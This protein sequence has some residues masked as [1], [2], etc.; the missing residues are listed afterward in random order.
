MA[1]FI[2]L[3][4]D[5]FVQAFD[6]ELADTKGQE[7]RVRRPMRG[8]Q[9]RRDQP[10][11]ITIIDK[12]GKSIPIIDAGGDQE[13]K[14]KGYSARFTNFLVT[15]YSAT[16]QERSQIVQTFGEDF[17]FFYGDQPRVYQ[18]QGILMHTADFNWRNEFIYNYENYLRGT[19]LLERNARAYLVQSGLMWEGYVMMFSWQEVA[20]QPNHV[21]FTMQ[22]LVTNETIVD[23]VGDV[24]F[25]IF[26]GDNATGILDKPWAFTA[27]LQQFEMNRRIL[28]N[29]TNFAA[30]LSSF[31]LTGGASGEQT[32]TRKPPL[33]SKI[34]DNL[35]EYWGGVL[36]PSVNL[37]ELAK[38][39]RKMTIRRVLYLIKEQYLR[40]KFVLDSARRL[41]A[42]EQGAL[43]TTFGSAF[44]I[45]SLSQ[46]ILRE[47]EGT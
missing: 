22:F 15:G 8:V 42:G 46:A 11:Y 29:R 14:G 32:F 47:I 28:P 44:I 33:R 16:R 27:L 37:N 35:D 18:I 3:S 5:P 6:Q 2:E 39:K 4:E 43:A 45:T 9:L 24:S 20:A 10:A 34:S 7:L 30:E 23:G 25:P 13:E 41:S 40:A 1:V 38:A 26:G 36:K 12:F 19:K 31:I 21:T 17:T